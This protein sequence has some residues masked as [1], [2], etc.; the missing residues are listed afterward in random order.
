MEGGSEGGGKRKKEE[1]R[2]TFLKKELKIS[3]RLLWLRI[4]FA[5]RKGPAAGDARLRRRYF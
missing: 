3:R 2:K 4:I 1:E 5:K